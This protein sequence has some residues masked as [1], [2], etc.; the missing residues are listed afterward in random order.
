MINIKI[1]LKLYIN[2]M[3][4]LNKPQLQDW[5]KNNKYPLLSIDTRGGERIWACWVKGDNVY[6]TDGLI[7]GKLKEPLSHKYVKNKLRTGIEQAL[8]EAEKKWIKQCCKGYKPLENDLYG[9]KIYDHVINQKNKNGGMNRGV[10]MFS[11]TTIKTEYTAGNTSLNIQHRPMLAKKYKEMKNDEFVLSTSGSKLR[12][13]CYVQPKVDGIRALSQIDKDGNVHLES[14]NGNYF[15]HLEHIRNEIKKFLNK[16]KYSNIILDGELYVHNLY[17]NDNK[18]MTNVER[19]QFISESCK[20]TRKEPHPQET[21]V[22]YWLFD[23]WDKTLTFEE[24]ISLLQYLYSKYDGNIIQIVPSIKVKSHEEI[25]RQMSIFVGENNNRNGYEFEGLMVRISEAKYI[26]STTHT[27]FL[28]K[29]KRFMDDEWEIYDAQDCVGGT[30]NGSIK[31]LCK[32]D[33]K[34]VVAKQ[35]GD[36][37]LSKKLYIMYKNNPSEFIGKMINLRYNE[38]SKDGIP[39][40]PRATSFVEDK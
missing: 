10:K 40:F 35:M 12:F 14:R 34:T 20:I 23:I 33:N 29:Y 26:S 28:L 36:S 15:V 1:I 3:E 7:N 31:W 18:E 5:V 30:Q 38:M 11:E 37:V 25:E 17:T 9:K 27:S 16:K 22:Q 13:P 32:K 24:R 6:K 2:N 19:Y 21:K 8:L 4:L 39:R